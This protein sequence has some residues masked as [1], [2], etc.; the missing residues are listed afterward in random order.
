MRGT[1]RRLAATIVLVSIAA[2]AALAQTAATPGPGAKSPEAPAI[3]IVGSRRIPRALFESRSQSASQTFRARNSADLPEEMVPLFRRQVLENMIRFELLILEAQHRGITAGAAGAESLIQRDPFFNPGGHYDPA[4]FAAV[5]AANSAAYQKAIAEL[6]LEL[7]AGKLQ[8]RLEAENQP[9]G[10]QLRALA[11]RSLGR[12]SL[13]YLDIDT[14]EFDGRLREPREREVI[15]SYRAHAGEYRQ[16]QRAEISVIF[17]D[18]PTLPDSLRA[19]PGQVKAWDARLRARADS[20]LAALRA[21]A[22]FEDVAESFGGARTRVVVLP[23][24][25]PGYWLGSREQSASVFESRPGVLLAQ[26]IASNPGYLVVR[27]DGVTPPHLASLAEVSPQIRRRLRDD[28]RLHDEDRTL[29]A[30]YAQ[31]GDSLSGPAVKVRYATADTAALDPGEPDDAE[32]D[33]FYRG[34]LADYST[35]DSRTGNIQSLPLADVRGDARLR[36]RH[37]RR[38]EMAQALAEGLSRAWSAGRRDAALERSATMFREA[39]P[40]P[41]GALIDTGLAASVVSDSIDARGAVSQN[42][43]VPYPRGFLIYQVYEIIP[44]YRP[45]FE[46]AR[47][48]LRA[49]KARHQEAVDRAAAHAWFD[50]DPRAWAIGNT[51]HLSRFVIPIPPPAEVPLTRA[52]VELFYRTHFNDYSAPEGLRARHILI[53]PTGPGPEA[54]RIARERADSLL[55]VLRAGADF[56]AVAK[57]VS[58]DPATRPLGGDLGQFGRGAMLQAFERAAFL[59]KAGELSEPVRTVEGYHIIQCVEHVPAYA[60]PLAW[61][62][63][64]VGYDAAVLKGD[65]LAARRADS[66]YRHVRTPAEAR[67]AAR[68]LGLSVEINTHEI[69]NYVASPDVK[70]Y[71]IKLDTVKPGALYPGPHLLKGMGYTITWVDSISGRQQP[72]WAQV[73]TRVFDEYRRGASTRAAQAKL[74][75]LDSMSAAGWSFDSLGTLWGGLVRKRGVPL[76]T[77]FNDLVGSRSLLDSLVYG[78]RGGRALQVGEISGWRAL[79]GRFARFR[80]VER[81]DPPPTAMAQRMESDRRAALDRAMRPL[82]DEMS[83]RY[84]VQILD[85]DLRRLAVPAPPPAPPGMP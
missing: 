83:H 65:S 60:Q 56:A 78:A 68:K 40:I 7:A 77:G 17:V 43:V 75:E 67:A 47:N 31:L 32:L 13:D 2:Y 11:I 10:E 35:F 19:L 63:G 25:F 37:D 21:G 69:G 54:D 45:T 15:D 79:P 27:V 29:G 23:D 73:E 61:V 74:A 53:S 48:S 52:E 72:L 14:R 16:G 59:M 71:L 5:K 82:F 85:P 51:L 12:V 20:A 38:A 41:V 57:Q 46:Q 26:P 33:R 55:R 58:D 80:L 42:E 8:T 22:A 81:I 1:F 50:R 39:G 6:R 30:L 18:R 49:V 66:V 84:G 70:P 64:N 28:A 9:S 62:Y 24:N 34:H 76:A 4:K 36:W 3:A 44:R